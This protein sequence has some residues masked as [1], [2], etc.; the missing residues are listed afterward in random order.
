MPASTA[1]ASSDERWRGGKRRPAAWVAASSAGDKSGLGACSRLGLLVVASVLLAEGPQLGSGFPSLFGRT[2][3]AFRRQQQAQQQQQQSAGR[4]EQLV[5]QASG[6]SAGPPRLLPVALGA[7]ASAAQPSGS[8]EPMVQQL[9]SQQVAAELMRIAGG[10]AH[11]M[12]ALA[13]ALHGQ[14]QPLQTAASSASAAAHQLGRMHQHQQAA[15][16]LDDAHHQLHQLQAQQQQTYASA[17][18]HNKP[19]SPVLE[20][21]QQHDQ[22][23]LLAHDTFDEPQME[24]IDH[25]ASPRARLQQGGS[26]TSEIVDKIEQHIGRHVEQSLAASRKAPEQEKEQHQQQQQ[27]GEQGGAESSESA[28]D[29]AEGAGQEEA[30][31]EKGAEKRAQTG[32]ESQ[33]GEH[34]EPEQEHSQ[35]SHSEAEQHKHH[36]QPPEAFEVHHKKGGKSFQY[37][38]QGHQH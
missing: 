7:G 2:P 19:S 9:R 35:S 34:Q 32:D 20:Q 3:F 28:Q 33:S 15:H 38:H 1:T 22:A 12:P 37:F 4:G 17:F 23:A 8:L 27:Y 26:Q 24:L 30:A 25:S 31:V 18:Y 10:G 29:E 11:Q 5:P 6:L 13:A 14:Q 36:E 16:Q 21:Q